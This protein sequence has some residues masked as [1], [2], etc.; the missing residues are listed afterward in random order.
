MPI[1]IAEPA[2]IVHFFPSD[3]KEMGDNSVYK[4]ILHLSLTKEMRVFLHGTIRKTLLKFAFV[5]S[6]MKKCPGFWSFTLDQFMLVGKQ[7]VWLEKWNYKM[8]N[9]MKI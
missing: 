3:L 4:T 2:V 6:E 5:V 7:S 8:I 9:R 1:K